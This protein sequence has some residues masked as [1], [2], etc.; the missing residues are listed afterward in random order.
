VSGGF[1]NFEGVTEWRLRESAAA[2]CK[3]Q[4]K[5]NFPI[6]HLVGGGGG[7]DVAWW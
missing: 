7:L 5:M 3:N 6:M 4:K 1:S 2:E